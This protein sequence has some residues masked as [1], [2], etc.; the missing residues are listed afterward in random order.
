MNI[1]FPQKNHQRY[2]DLHYKYL[3]SIFND[4]KLSIELKEIEE[5]SDTVLKCY[6]DEKLVLFDFS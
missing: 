2:Y 6:I 3:L 1:I 5:Y 4:Q